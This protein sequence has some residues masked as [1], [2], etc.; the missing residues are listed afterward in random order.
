M[1]AFTA[2]SAVLFY[3]RIKGVLRHAP[4][5]LDDSE[6]FSAEEIDKKKPKGANAQNRTVDEDIAA[7]TNLY[8]E[9]VRFCKDTIEKTGIVYPYPLSRQKTGALKVDSSHSVRAVGTEGARRATGV[10]TAAPCTSAGLR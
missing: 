5:V 10:P 3:D 8:T 9:L 7:V 1:Q 2:D 4:S 6:E